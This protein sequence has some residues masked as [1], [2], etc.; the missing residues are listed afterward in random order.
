MEVSTAQTLER[1][2]GSPRGFVAQSGSRLRPPSPLRSD[3]R[4]S[5]WRPEL[6][7]LDAAGFAISDYEDFDRVGKWEHCHPSCHEAAYLINLHAD[8]ASALAAIPERGHALARRICSRRPGELTR[9]GTLSF[10]IYRVSVVGLVGYDYR[11]VGCQMPGWHDQL[12]SGRGDEPAWRE[13]RRQREREEVEGALLPGATAVGDLFMF[14][15]AAP[16]RM[17]ECDLVEVVDWG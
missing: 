3:R 6:G 2:A 1:P 7:S 10:S 13:L 14:A 9:L 5:V 15:Q 4:S 12:H 8:L 17:V 16:T 11:P